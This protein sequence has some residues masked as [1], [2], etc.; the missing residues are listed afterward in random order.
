MSLSDL[1]RPLHRSCQRS[2]RPNIGRQ[3]ENRLKHC[4]RARRTGRESEE[5][6][7][8]CREMRPP[9]RPACLHPRALCQQVKRDPLG[10]LLRRGGVLEPRESLNAQRR[11]RHRARRMVRTGVGDVPCNRQRPMCCRAG[12]PPTVQLRSKQEWS[13]RQLTGREAKSVP[14]QRHQRGL[15]S[16]DRRRRSTA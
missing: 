15:Q 7:P 10:R 8:W 5:L 16:R 3:D 2:A 9:K 14:R 12:L 11:A 1:A 13:L 6:A 4:G